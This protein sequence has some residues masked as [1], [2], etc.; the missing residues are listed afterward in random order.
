MNSSNLEVASYLVE[1]YTEDEIEYLRKNL[2]KNDSNENNLSKDDLIKSLEFNLTEE[3]RIVLLCKY[4][5]L[6]PPT[7]ENLINHMKDSSLDNIGDA[8]EFM[9]KHAPKRKSN[10]KLPPS[11]IDEFL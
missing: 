7:K 4:F 10:K 11:W 2:I 9:K 1:N 6:T 8:F 3:Y 5:S